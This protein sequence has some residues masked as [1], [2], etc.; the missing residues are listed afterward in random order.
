[1]TPMD[2]RKIL[3]EIFTTFPEAIEKLYRDLSEDYAK[4]NLIG[5]STEETLIRVYENSGK[6]KAL[7]DLMEKFR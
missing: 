4:E 3:R 6:K 2:H 5:S 7:E 1:M